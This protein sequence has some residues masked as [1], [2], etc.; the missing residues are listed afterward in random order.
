MF[1]LSLI[2]ALL[3]APC[4]QPGA[5]KASGTAIQVGRSFSTSSRDVSSAPAAGPIKTRI[6][7]CAPSNTAVDDLAWRIHKSCIGPSG[8]IGGLRVVRFGLLPGE[9]RHEGRKRTQHSIRS[10]DSTFNARRDEFLYKINL[11]RIAATSAERRDILMKSHVVCTTLNSAGSKA[12]IDAATREDSSEFDVVIIDEACQASEPSCLIPFKFNPDAVIM[13]GDPQQ[14]PVTVRSQS[15]E[16]ANL[17]R[18]FFQRLQDCG[19]PVEMLRIQ[20]RMYHEIARF[21]SSQFYGGQLITSPH[22]SKRF[23]PWYRHPCFPPLLVWNVRN[24]SMA[25]NR[26]GGICNHSEKNFIVQN[27]LP[28]FAKEISP[29]HPIVQVGIIS[30]YSDQVSSHELLTV[31]SVD[32]AMFEH[33]LRFMDVGLMYELLFVISNIS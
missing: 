8:T 27:L 14:L 23:S 33:V 7:V 4:P 15:A 11:E 32:V 16:K 21:P 29:E 30:F 6:L 1:A 9:E 19:W 20:Y 10:K 31:C 12:F 5:W 28:A 22:L 2:S 13:V 26:K 18:S 24:G 3:N 25:R 17:G